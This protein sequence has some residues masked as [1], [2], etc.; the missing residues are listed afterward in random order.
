LLH[1]GASWRYKQ[2]KAKNV[3]TL[4]A[5]LR[6]HSFALKV[7]AGPGDRSIIN[8][9]REMCGTDLPVEYPSMTELYELI[10]GAH[11]V[12]CNN[13]AALHIAEA[14]GTPC[15]A[16]TGPS[17]PVRWG[18]YRPHSRTVTRSGGLPCHPC[19]EKRCVLS[20][21][22]CIDRIELVDVIEALEV[23]SISAGQR[24]LRVR[25]LSSN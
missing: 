24:P 7:V 4:I 11:V 15:L 3:A 19:G 18:T 23:L 14:L 8:A 16:L 5:W 21:N 6:E 20:E 13:S 9:I 10:A 25:A 12:I 1:P 17:D 2:W 22:P